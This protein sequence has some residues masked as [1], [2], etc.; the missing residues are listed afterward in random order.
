MYRTCVNYVFT[1]VGLFLKLISLN[2]FYIVFKDSYNLYVFISV[3]K[4]IIVLDYA[5][6]FTIYKYVVYKMSGKY[7]VGYT[8][9]LRTNN[10]SNINWILTDDIR[11]CV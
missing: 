2:S 7:T 9:K 5:I 8:G 10:V 11:G 6:I 1:A 3:F 4:E